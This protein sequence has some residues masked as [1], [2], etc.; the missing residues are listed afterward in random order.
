[1]TAPGFTVKAAGLNPLAHYLQYGIAEGRK[2]NPASVENSSEIVRGD[3]WKY[4][5]ISGSFCQMQLKIE[6]YREFSLCV[7][8]PYMTFIA[9]SAEPY[10]G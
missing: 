10:L 5:R 6:T 1:M 8:A 2:P 9:L 3:H 4:E 7:L